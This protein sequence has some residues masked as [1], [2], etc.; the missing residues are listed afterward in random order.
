MMA[1]VASKPAARRV[2]NVVTDIG[3]GVPKSPV[4]HELYVDASSSLTIRDNLLPPESPT[5]RLRSTFEHCA[6]KSPLK[7][8]HKVK[9]SAE[10]EL[11]L[12]RLVLT[13][14][15]ILSSFDNILKL[16]KTLPFNEV[17]TRSVI[18]IRTKVR[19]IKKQLQQQ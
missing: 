16:L 19:D 4:V 3:A 14:D 11:I 7:F 15:P 10:E 2:S 13:N 12:R 6:L 17:P 1:S 18:S 9:Y 5:K 8:P